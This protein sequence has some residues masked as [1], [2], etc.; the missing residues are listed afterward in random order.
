MWCN[1]ERTELGGEGS[2]GD[3]EHKHE[4]EFGDAP[5]ESRRFEGAGRREAGCG[6]TVVWSAG[7]CSNSFS[8]ARDFIR[9]SALK[10][11]LL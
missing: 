2:A 7:M 6:R 8:P 4:G 3:R 1:R 10:F 5:A 11:R 9:V